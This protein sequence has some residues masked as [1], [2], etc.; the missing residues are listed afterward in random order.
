M[1]SAVRK[2]STSEHSTNMRTLEDKAK[3][4]ISEL[5]LLLKGGDLSDEERAALEDKIKKMILAIE[6]EQKKACCK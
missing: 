3:S 2:L 1:A 6:L 5:Y 4:D